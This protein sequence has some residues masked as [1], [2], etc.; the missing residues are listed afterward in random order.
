MGT[1]TGIDKDVSL[2]ERESIT[3][4]IQLHEMVLPAPP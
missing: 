3:K 2:Y 1:P 4:T